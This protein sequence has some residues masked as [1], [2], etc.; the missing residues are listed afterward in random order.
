MKKLWLLCLLV[1]SFQGYLI[2][3]N[4]GSS[5]NLTASTKTE[6][7]IEVNPYTQTTVEYTNVKGYFIFFEDPIWVRIGEGDIDLTGTTENGY[8]KPW[9]KKFFGNGLNDMTILDTTVCTATSDISYSVQ[10]S[11]EARASTLDDPVF[12]GTGL[13]DL[14]VGGAYDTD[15]VYDYMYFVVRIDA[16][17]TPDTF[18]WW[19]WDETNEWV[20]QASG[21]AIT[22]SSQDLSNDVT[23][24]FGATTGHTVGDYWEIYAEKENPVKADCFTWYVNENGNWTLGGKDV[25]ITGDYQTLNYGTQIKFGATTGHK[26]GDEWTFDCEGTKKVPN[27]AVIHGDEV[28]A[29][30]KDMLNIT[31][32]KM[33]FLGDDTQTDTGRVVIWIY[34]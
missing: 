7:V 11:K 33:N 26:L 13:D 22:G 2:A 21:V 25:V 34:Q 5:N 15:I 19:T 32:F 20:K 1:F 3:G 12:T 24:T 16:T 6:T 8:P 4:F 28:S 23:V 14:S 27:Y 31:D 17:G 18:E 29:I 9:T 10:I 30:F